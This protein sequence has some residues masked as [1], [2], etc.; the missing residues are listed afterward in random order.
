MHERIHIYGS[1]TI[2][3][4]RTAGGAYAGAT[5]GH[6]AGASA[7]IGGSTDSEYGSTGGQ[8]AESHAFGKSK[9]VVKLYD[10]PHSSA[11]VPATPQLVAEEAPPKLDTRIGNEVVV[12]KTVIK[13]K[14]V[15]EVS[16]I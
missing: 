11:P 13:K 12:K 7:A 1:I 9:S 4:G 16:L 5:S 10:I 3:A 6:G 2:L 8:H 15:P 14:Y